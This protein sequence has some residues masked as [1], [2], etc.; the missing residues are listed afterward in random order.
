MAEIT[1]EGQVAFTIVSD[2]HGDERLLS[3][4]LAE[5]PKRVL[6]FNKKKRI[7]RGKGW[8]GLDKLVLIGN[9]PG[10]QLDDKNWSKFYPAW[11]Y[12]ENKFSDFKRM[13]LFEN[14][15]IPSSIKEY[16]PAALA[17]WFGKE[18]RQ[19][20]DRQAAKDFL[21]YVGY[22]DWKAGKW[23]PDQDG[24][25]TQNY[26]KFWRSVAKTV[27]KAPFHVRIMPTDRVYLEEVPAQYDL[28]WDARK[29]GNLTFRSMPIRKIQNKHFV[30]ALALGPQDRAGVP[31]DLKMF[32]PLDADVTIAYLFP[33]EF[34]EMLVAQPR[35]RLLI[36][37][38]NLLEKNEVRQA[39][40]HAHPGTVISEEV[41]NTV[42]TYVFNGRQA[43]RIKHKWDPSKGAFAEDIEEFIK[44]AKPHLTPTALPQDMADEAAYLQLFSKPEMFEL[45]KQE[46]RNL[47]P[48]ASEDPGLK[49]VNTFGKLAHLHGG[50]VDRINEQGIKL[51]EAHTALE[52]F[53]SKLF[54]ALGC[55]DLYASIKEAVW[56]KYQVVPGTELP[57]VAHADL[58]KESADAALQRVI[59]AVDAV[60]REKTNSQNLLSKLSTDLSLGPI[61]SEIVI[62]ARGKYQLG[63]EAPLTGEAIDYV[64]DNI[65][66][67]IVS[68]HVQHVDLLKKALEELDKKKSETQAFQVE[69]G[70]WEEERKSVSRVLAGC[71]EEFGIRVHGPTL[72]DGVQQ[73]AGAVRDYK[74]KYNV[75]EKQCIEANAV[76]GSKQ[77]ELETLRREKEASIDAIGKEL[78]EKEALIEHLN[79]ELKKYE[80]Q[81]LGDDDVARQKVID[82]RARELAR[83]R[84]EELERQINGLEQQNASLER[85]RET[86]ENAYRELRDH[87]QSELEGTRKSETQYKLRAQSAYADAFKEVEQRLK[88]KDA[89]IGELERL[90]RSQGEN[91]QKAVALTK[92]AERLCAKKPAE[93]AELYK[94]AYELAPHSATKSDVA[95]NVG[96]ALYRL[97]EKGSSEAYAEAIL[98][99]EK[100]AQDKE[101]KEFLA[102]CRSKAVRRPEPK[103][104]K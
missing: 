62:E 99:F 15:R 72:L 20:I 39:R 52:T 79:G 64:R 11:G 1:L 101:T 90:L 94:K 75:S 58:S 6:A 84:I 38:F 81:L 66:A 80:S 7:S 17:G 71:S 97:A 78:A 54:D 55:P 12:L 45:F 70:K 57:E 68:Q 49:D 34:D 88:D 2:L 18:G 16:G 73:L 46:L 24:L 47:N 10:H 4:V 43:W 23:D 56:K 104:G 102:Y 28:S 41:R 36:S 93:A 60:A 92:V 96:F 100:A 31:Y 95:F 50:Y 40:A 74:S 13:G 35:E 98:W 77:K 14:G 21:T 89:R 33:A 53:C 27:S 22:R 87:F 30:H 5:V 32:S 37:T 65:V 59:R 19:N 67:R 61:Y 63:P 48:K 85:Q 26:R 51:M 103:N 76:I 29:L 91:H 25:A 8:P 9:T 3:A 69:Q 86:A 82:E 83:G 42:S 44:F